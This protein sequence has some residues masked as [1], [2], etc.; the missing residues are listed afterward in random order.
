MFVVRQK[1]LG[2]VSVNVPTAKEGTLIK[3]NFKMYPQTQ[4]PQ[5]I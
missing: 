4:K 3:N 2:N 5:Q 1:L